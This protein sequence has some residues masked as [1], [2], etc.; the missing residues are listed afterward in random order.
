[1]R[2]ERSNRRPWWRWV[3]CQVSALLGGVA[4][5]GGP[6][7]LNLSRVD[8][9]W[10]QS[11]VETEIHCRVEG[12]DGNLQFW[13]SFPC[14]AVADRS[15]GGGG[16]AHFRVTI[17]ADTPSGFGY[18]CLISS[19]GLTSPQLVAWDSLPV[20]SVVGGERVDTPAVVIG[21]EG[22]FAGEFT[23]GRANWFRWEPAKDSGGVFEVIA[24][25]LGSV[26]DPFLDRCNA[27]GRPVETLEDTAGA[28]VDVRWMA[29]L[30]QA[31]PVWFRIRD[32]AWAGG[33]THRYWCRIGKSAW[34]GAARFV[35]PSARE[36]TSEAGVPETEPNDDRAH[37][38]PLGKDVASLVGT[39]ARRGDVDI[40]VFEAPRAGRYQFRGLTR[41]LG[42]AVDLRLLV[43]GEDGGILAEAG[44]GDGDSAVLEVELNAGQQVW[45][46]VSELT[47]GGGPDSAYRVEIGP[48]RGLIASTEILAAAGAAGETVEVKVAL[49]GARAPKGRIRF[50]LDGTPWQMEP[51]EIAADLKEVVLKIRIPAEASPGTVHPVRIACQLG[52]TGEWAGT[53]V[54]TRPGIRKAWPG[55]VTPLESMDGWVLVG[56]LK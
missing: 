4:A 52:K 38:T 50:S 9:A 22:V 47:G 13:S 39:L 21:A 34:T 11:G 8:P 28:G 55:W 24:G 51:G 32:S 23:A 29:L 3:S 14:N 15:A 20:R 6:A 36:A 16:K 33:A 10:L 19:N 7:P 48:P 12:G 17:P 49:T 56:V 37:A 46:E 53:R 43:R 45:L 31:D 42:S 41:T 35:M 2:N 44:G 26:A 30:G 40:A 18:V 5:I 27:T 25:R 1:M 54:T